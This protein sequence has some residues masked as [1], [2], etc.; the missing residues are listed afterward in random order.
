MR[1][2]DSEYGKSALFVAPHATPAW[3]IR[4]SDVGAPDY[5]FVEV[6]P[7]GLLSSDPFPENW[8]LSPFAKKEYLASLRLDPGYLK[9]AN[10]IFFRATRRDDDLERGILEGIPLRHDGSPVWWTDLDRGPVKVATLFDLALLPNKPQPWKV[11]RGKKK[12]KE[13]WLLSL[14]QWDSATFPPA[15]KGGPPFVKGVSTAAERL[16]RR[17]KKG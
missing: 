16:R 12:A 13:L 6:D 15:S 10:E 9:L 2:K 17:R 5:K 3:L 7:D 1:A 8:P 14:A 4:G 11:G